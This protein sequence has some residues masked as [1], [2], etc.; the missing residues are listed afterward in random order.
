MHDA[1]SSSSSN[2]STL[3][4]DQQEQ[5][6]PYTFPARAARITYFTSETCDM[7]RKKSSRS[8]VSPLSLQMEGK[9]GK[10][11]EKLVGLGGEGGRESSDQLEMTLT[12]IKIRKKKWLLAR[13]C[14]TRR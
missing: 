1:D 2:A 13:T 3:S 10:I 12:V 9:G 4:Q 5:T 11:R 14:E 7:E 6:V 8:N